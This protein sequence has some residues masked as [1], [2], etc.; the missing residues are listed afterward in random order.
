ML[1]QFNKVDAILE[2]LSLVVNNDQI[3]QIPNKRALNDGI[4]DIR[5]AIDTI[6]KNAFATISPLNIVMLNIALADIIDHISN[7]VSKG[8]TSMDEFDQSPNTQQQG[9][10][11]QD[12]DFDAQWA[13]LE[14]QISSLDNQTKNVGLKWYNKTYRKLNDYVIQ[15]SIKHHIPQR[16][17]KLAV[18]SAIA[19]Y[20]LWFRTESGT[21]VDMMQE[22]HTFNE[23]TRDFFG[24]Y[25]HSVSSNGQE[26][27]DYH[28][29]KPLKWLGLLEKK[30]FDFQHGLMP[31]GATLL[32]YK[33]L[34]DNETNDSYSWFKKKV[35]TAHNNL[36]G[37]AYASKKVV[38]DDAMTG[39]LS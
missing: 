29:T 38:S 16:A 32:G 9:F 39:M 15:P 31:V 14:K 21:R 26:V 33:Y 23:K 4:K 10:P 6:N 19:G 13:Y 27:E 34:F 18:A 36:L 20:F 24:P 5:G 17:T 1:V 28:T 2:D 22:P 35:M 25:F 37:G 11:D 8:F 30:M 12:L 7:A 3:K